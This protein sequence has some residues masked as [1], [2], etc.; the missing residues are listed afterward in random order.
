MRSTRR[1]GERWGRMARISLMS[2]MAM[3]MAIIAAVDPILSYLQAQQ[4][5]IVALIRQFVECES[6]SD[7]PEAVNRFVELVSD[8]VAAFAKV[9]TTSGGK[10]G[11]QAV[12][13][14][15]L[16]DHRQYGQMLAMAHSD[17]DRP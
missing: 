9:K 2:R 17:M 3:E 10:F 11:Q 14:M 5:A 12:C 8:T 16:P 13:E 4:T 6:P 15:T 7:T 1:K